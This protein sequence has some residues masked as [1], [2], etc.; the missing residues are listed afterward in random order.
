MTE[1]DPLDHP[2]TGARL[3]AYEP[4]GAPG[5]TAGLVHEDRVVPL[6]DALTQVHGGSWADRSPA[7]E[8]WLR[9]PGRVELLLAVES[10]EE[11]LRP[12]VAGLADLAGAPDAVPLDRA[13]LRP[14]VRQPQKI[15]AV[16]LNY[17][18]HA[19]E[20][21]RTTSEYPV[22]FAKYA[23]TLTGPADD[24]PIPRASHRIDYEG[25]LAVVIGRRAAQVSRDDADAYIAG[26]AVAND[27]SAR[28]YQF[29]TKEMLQGKTFDHF[30][31]LGPWLTRPR[32]VGELGPLRLT[33]T[34]SGEVRQSATLG[35]M[36]FDVPYLIEYLSA[37]MTLLPGD[38]LLTGTPAGI[39]A[40]MRPRRWLRDGDIVEIEI[41]EIGRIGNRF[42]GAGGAA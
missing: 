2:L 39:G 12:V 23:N 33:T 38:V 40:A 1:A 19:A 27:V 10:W 7:A 4:A 42:V 37:F 6:P 3:V 24:V 36:I 9:S 41:E 26:Y 22:L 35:E 32:P 8:E 28:D 15:V 16:G 14:P 21:E 17:A 31:P 11:L 13:R 25:E 18:S 30:C 5:A 29:R 20:A 34:V